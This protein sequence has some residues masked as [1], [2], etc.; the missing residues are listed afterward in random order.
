MGLVEDWK[1]DIDERLR[2]GENIPQII[3]RCPQCSNISLSYDPETGTHGMTKTRLGFLDWENG[4]PNNPFPEEKL[5]KYG[6]ATLMGAG[7]HL[8]NSA[9]RYYFENYRAKDKTKMVFPKPC[10]YDRRYQTDKNPTYCTANR[11]H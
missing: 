4:D 1:K 5:K 8:L 3:K 10:E 9:G 7:S 11:K 6:F 2:K